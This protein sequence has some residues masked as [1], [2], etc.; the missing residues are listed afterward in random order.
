MT[1]GLMEVNLADAH[2]LSKYDFFHKIDPYVLIQYRDQEHKSSIA[3]GEGSNPKWN[4]KFTFRVEYPGA[5]EQPK[6]VFKIM[7][8]DTFSPDDYVGQTT[9]Y[10]KEVLAVGVEKGK[11]ELLLQKYRVVD[12]NQSYRGDIR[13]GLT[14]TPRVETESHAQE[15]GGWKESQW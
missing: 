10:L 4:Q 14:F 1:I 8:H 2:G 13:V 5:D 9:M 11:S 15:F 3:K 6:L 7:D 12:K